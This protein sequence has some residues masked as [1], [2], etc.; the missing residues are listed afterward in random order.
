[1]ALCHCRQ[2]PYDEAGHDG[3]IILTDYLGIVC[4]KDSPI[5]IAWKSGQQQA[6]EV[7]SIFLECNLEA[8]NTTALLAF[9][10]NRI[11]ATILPKSAMLAEPSLV[12]LRPSQ[13][14]AKRHL[15][16]IHSHDRQ[17]SPVSRLFW[18]QL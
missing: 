10:R 1:M 2:R 11:G 17:M 8:K 14:E 16:K 5:A 18:E 3:E 13:D 6:K 7:Q 4:H 12:F 9:V 15:I